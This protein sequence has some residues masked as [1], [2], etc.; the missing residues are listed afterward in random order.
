MLFEI[1]YGLELDPGIKTPKAEKSRVYARMLKDYL[2]KFPDEAVRRAFGR[3]M[4]N[5]GFLPRIS[6]FAAELEPQSGD[7]AKAAW[8]E[9]L[10]ML[11]RHGGLENQ[12][13]RTN[14]ATAKA[15]EVLGGWGH[16]SRRPFFELNKNSLAE[17]FEVAYKRAAALGL[18]GQAGNIAG[19]RG[20]D[21]RTGEYLPLSETGPAAAISALPAPRYLEGQKDGREGLIPVEY[22]EEIGALAKKKAM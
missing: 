20:K 2:R 1:N 9:V 18:S 19:V 21:W 7:E 4:K 14:Q 22:R 15:V 8:A 12:F 5:C 6:D 11:H 13:W 3:V 10:G 17:A 16:L